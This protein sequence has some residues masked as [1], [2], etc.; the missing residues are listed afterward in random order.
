MQKKRDQYTNRRG[1]KT[2]PVRI[3][4][5]EK[6]FQKAN[7]PSFAR[8]FPFFVQKITH[9]QANGHSFASILPFHFF[10]YLEKQ[11]EKD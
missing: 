3:K 7:G 10:Y 11:E 8:I 6:P 4:C 2:R 1:E 9:M 5:P